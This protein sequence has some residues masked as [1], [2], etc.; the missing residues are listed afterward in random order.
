MDERLLAEERGRRVQ[1]AVESLPP[2]WQS[3]VRLLMRDPPISYKEIADVLDMPIGSI[4]PTR[5]RCI[6]RIRAAL[7]SAAR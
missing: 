4:G 5:R 3:L 2:S 1:Q 6:S 7:E